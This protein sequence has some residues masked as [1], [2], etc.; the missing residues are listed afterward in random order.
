M[1]METALGSPQV[2]LGLSIFVFLANA[3]EAPATLAVAAA[4]VTKNRRDKSGDF[5][6][7]GF[8]SLDIGRPSQ[9]GVTTRGSPRDA[10]LQ[11][12]VRTTSKRDA[13]RSRRA[14]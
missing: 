10:P 3:L 4:A 6:L 12:P 11:A 9:I 7:S 5:F 2:I 14:L 13:T 1:S 8:F